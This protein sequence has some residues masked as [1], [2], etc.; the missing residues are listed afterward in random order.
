M[1][2]IPQHDQMDCGPA[3]ITMISAHFGKKHRIDYIRSIS[4][5]KRDGVS[6][7]GISQAAEK[8]GFDTH[9]SMLDLKTLDDEATL[10]CILHWN[11][12]HFVVLYDHKKNFFTGKYKYKI[13]DPSYGLITLT[14][15]EFKSRWLS[16]NDKG[17]ALF[18]NPTEEFYKKEVAKKKRINFKFLFDFLKPYKYEVFQLFLTLLVGSAFT[19]IFPFLTQSLIDEGVESKS[20][21]IIFMILLAQVFLF[22]GSII[23]EIVRNWIMLYIGTRINITIISDFFKKILK[24]PIHFFDSKLI[25]DFNQRIQDHERVEGFLT[26]QS[27]ITLFSIINFSIFFFVLIYYD[28]K[29]VIAYSV[30]TTIAILWSVYFLKKRRILDYYRFQR[31]S[32]NQEAIYEM[33]NGIQEIKLN[34]F[35]DLKRKEW[36]E[37][38]I[39]LFGVNLRSLK[40]DQ[41]QLMGFNF[42][43]QFKNIFVTFIAAR[44]VVLGN[45]S[46]GAMLAIAYI[47]GQM[48][49]PVNQLIN[50]FRSF[51]DAKL[52]MERLSEVQDQEEEEKAGQIQLSKEELTYQNGIEKGIRLNNVSYQYEGPKSPF[53]LKNINLFIPD[54]KTTAIVGASG[55]GK[56]TLMK[57]LLKFYEPVNGTIYVN[58]HELTNISPK[59]WR[60]NCGVVMQDGYIFSGTIERNIATRDEKI[61]ESR[62]QFATKTANIDGFIKELPQKLKTKI[63]ASGNGISGGQK[64]RVLI[65]RS[66]Y[67]DPHYIFFDEA[68]SALDAENE[69]IIHDNLLEFF[70]NK[71][72][73]IIAHRLSTVKNADQIVVL[74]KGE[75]VE[76]GTHKDLVSNHSTYYNLV[77]NQLELGN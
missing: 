24:L 12:N 46:L 40:L 68:T 75:I 50:F 57:I 73:V 27:L 61:K 30:L 32:E 15:E 39:K 8:I 43:N 52:S 23:M 34:S 21:S 3:C 36:E 6:L 10:P 2:L 31:R 51:Q 49:S 45:I 72:V 22:L 64:Q 19:L 4:Y 76:I 48:N 77:K 60:E 38:Q 69:K 44:E 11:Q 58:Q 41:F 62:L 28:V 42:I 26:S 13:A 1:K 20:L 14:Q 17:I 9:A 71:T 59:N 33:I 5:L 35:E 63:G 18:L 70:K 37:I 66:V 16:E 47:I 55:S 53:V 29:I 54:G 7:R 65:A 56:T 74:S 25:G 67:K